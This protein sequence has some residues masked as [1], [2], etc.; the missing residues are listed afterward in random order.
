[1]KTLEPGD[2]VA[3]RGGHIMRDQGPYC[4][5]GGIETP[6]TDDPDL[7]LAFRNPREGLCSPATG[8]SARQSD[9]THIF[10]GTSVCQQWLVTRL[11]D[12][13]HRCSPAAIRDHEAIM[14]EVL[15]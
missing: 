2:I 8:Y 14:K 4:G 6:Y 1:M 9:I 13:R 10:T 15:G 5:K 3:L 7:C 12:M 11:G